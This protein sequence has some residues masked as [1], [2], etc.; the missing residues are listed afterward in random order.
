MINLN[1]ILSYL[2]DN[3]IHDLEIIT[4]R[5]LDTGRAEII[6]LFGSYA[7]GDYKE[8]RG[9][10]KGKKSDYDILVIASDIPNRRELSS[11]L[12][13]VFKDI[14]IAVQLLVEYI[15]FVNS[16]LEERQ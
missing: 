6:V 15:E 10:T 1:E 16:N 13:E 8:Q 12:R 2:P 7:R 14:G 9:K 4:R 3:N 5:I 11:E